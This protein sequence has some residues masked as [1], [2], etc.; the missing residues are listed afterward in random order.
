MTDI[1]LEVSGKMGKGGLRKYDGALCTKY[2]IN[3]SD[4][5]YMQRDATNT[6]KK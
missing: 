3:R 2:F 1:Y 6:L 5:K 4:S